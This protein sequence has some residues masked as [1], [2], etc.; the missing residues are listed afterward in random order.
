MDERGTEYSD[1][2][3]RG[4]YTDPDIEKHPAL[5][6]LRANFPDAIVDVVRFRDETTIH[7]RRETLRDVCL[8]LKD[9]ERLNFNFLTD[10][11]AVDMLRLRVQP[12][13]DVVVML[14]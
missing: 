3:G 7:I 1:P 13:F 8:F 14:Y 9:H 5:R 2:W 10:V 4:L 6:E 11:T 12:R